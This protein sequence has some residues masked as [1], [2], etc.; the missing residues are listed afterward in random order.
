MR[1]VAFILLLGFLVVH[2][3]STQENGANAFSGIVVSENGT[4]IEGVEVFA[5][6]QEITNADGKFD[7]TNSPNKDSLISFYK[8]E[9]RPKALVV[10]PRNRTVRVVLEDDAKTAWL[11]H[12]C[13]ANVFGNFHEGYELVFHWPKNLKAIQI[14]DIDYLEDV[15]RLEK[16]SKPLQLWYG[17]L[18]SPARTVEQLTLQSVSF[19]Q[20]SIHSKSGQVVGQDRRGKTK[21]GLWRSA[22]FL[23]LS[24]SAIYESVSEQEAAAYDQIIDSVCQR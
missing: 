11:I 6:E 7:L 15:I 18:V 12:A 16:Y 5:W 24:T 20:R 23:G 1:K 2:P 10:T 22:D 3:V 21:D 14:K 13:P 9:F 8:E 19:D 4:P 17:A